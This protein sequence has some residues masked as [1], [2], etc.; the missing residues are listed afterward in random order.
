MQAILQYILAKL[1]ILG[2]CFDYE[3]GKSSEVQINLTSYKICVGLSV[4]SSNHSVTSSRKHAYIIL[5]PLNPTFVYKTGVLQGY[6]L[7]FLFLLKN[8]HFG[9]SLESPRRGGSNEYPQ[10]MF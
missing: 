9:Y 6:T 5:T 4:S 10:S 2:S 1:Y 7:F 8:I 3:R